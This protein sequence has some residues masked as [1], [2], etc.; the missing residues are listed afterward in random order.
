[1]TGCGEPDRATAVLTE[2]SV[3]ATIPFDMRDSMA[4]S[5]DLPARDRILDAAEDA[6]SEDGFSG[7]AMKDI[8][9]RAGV[10]QGLLHYHFDNKDG[11]YSAVVHRRASAINAERIERLD[12]VDMTGP[13]ALEDIVAAFIVPPL[14]MSGGGR[15]YARI[16]AG[17]VS[18]NARDSA[19]VSANYDTTATR[20]LDALQAAC[21]GVSRYTVSQGYHMAL[22]ALSTT[23]ARNGRAERLAGEE[24]DAQDMDAQAR[25]LVTFV[26]GG[27]VALIGTT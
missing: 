5:T 12:R 17:L 15:A 3:S 9:S 6:F 26:T 2:R 18:G 13:R 20:F 8:A 22:G 1:M 23:L 4:P 21:P 11:L 10:A 16:F 7:A 25:N 27:I 19:V 14:G 24:P